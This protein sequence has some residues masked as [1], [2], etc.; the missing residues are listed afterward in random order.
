MQPKPKCEREHDTEME[1]FETSTTNSHVQT[2][3]SS[4]DPSHQKND[5]DANQNKRHADD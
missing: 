3:N 2:W 4:Y 1:Q 5:F